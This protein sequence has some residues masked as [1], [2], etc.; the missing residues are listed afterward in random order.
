MKGR[1]WTEE[2][3]KMLISLAGTMR[4][5]DIGDIMGRSSD[6]IRK[7]CTK[8]GLSLICKG[9]NTKSWT[10]EERDILTDCLSRG[11][12]RKAI[13][14][15]L[16]RSEASIA[17]QIQRMAFREELDERE[18]LWGDFSLMALRVPV[19]EIASL[20]NKYE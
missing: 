11:M 20:L 6:S 4:S 15:K 10:D 16:G 2:D 14:K 3:D 17:G 13:S 12:S 19:C 9:E 8:L 18:T 7:R 1:A 5:P